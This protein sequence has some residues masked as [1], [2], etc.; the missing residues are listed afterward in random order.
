MK[1]STPRPA[2]KQISVW[3]VFV[4]ALICV[5][6]ATGMIAGLSMWPMI[7]VYWMVLAIKNF[8]DWI[9]GIGK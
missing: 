6:V 5:V 7:I 8:A 3:L 4:L 1:H 9:G 2:A